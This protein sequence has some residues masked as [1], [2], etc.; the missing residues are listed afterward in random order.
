MSEVDGLN[1]VLKEP[2]VV[3]L[4]LRQ[5]VK[6]LD[7]DTDATSDSEELNEALP[8]DLVTPKEGDS[9]N[10]CWQDPLDVGEAVGVSRRETVIEGALLLDWDALLDAV[11]MLVRVMDSE[12]SLLPLLPADLVMLDRSVAV[13]KTETL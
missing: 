3:T 2:L 1:D 4:A 9:L 10:D 13:D 11:L 5:L 7:A 8:L 6:L 12:V